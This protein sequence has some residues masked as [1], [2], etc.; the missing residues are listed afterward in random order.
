M[1]RV[2]NFVALGASRGRWICG[3]RPRDI[4]SS[5]ARL[6]FAALLEKS[7]G[8]HVLRPLQALLWTPN[9]RRDSPTCEHVV[10]LTRKVLGNES[11]NRTFHLESL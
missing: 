9:S 6:D 4:H 5:I 10:I 8:S 7:H 3:S 11:F 2:L 1:D